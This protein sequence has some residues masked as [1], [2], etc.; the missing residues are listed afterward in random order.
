MRIINATRHIAA[1]VSFLGAVLLASTAT[2]QH[3]YPQPVAPASAPAYGHAPAHAHRPQP[4][5]HPAYH[6]AAAARPVQPTHAVHNPHQR[7]LARNTATRPAS[8]A[9]DVGFLNELRRRAEHLAA[10]RLTYDF[11][12][13]DPSRG[14]LDCSGAM[15]HLLSSMGVPGVPRTSY[16]QYEWLVQHRTMRHTQ[17]IPS[18]TGPNSG[19]HPGDL[20]FW[21]G[22]YD[23]GHKVS[24]VMLYLGQ[25]PDG[26][27]YMFGARG[28]SK[29]GMNGAGVD[30][31]ELKPGYHKSLVGIG[32]IPR[33]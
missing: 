20:I 4:Q 29:T 30:I 11:G 1:G 5:I 13:S 26:R 17:T 3:H 7:P 12:S 15:L 24:H 14:G 22:T 2:A 25:G 21:G 9:Q 28:K 10:S 31:F 23:S 19:L 6:N 27:H 16:Q 32:S 8:P 33:I 18:Q